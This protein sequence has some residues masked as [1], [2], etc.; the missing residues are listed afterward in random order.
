MRSTVHRVVYPEDHGK[1]TA[2]KGDRYSIAFF[3]HPNKNTELV[4][5]PS[6]I[7]R[8]KLGMAE[9]PDKAGG[10][11]MTAMEHLQSRL[12]ATYRWQKS[13]GTAVAAS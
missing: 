13:E 8:E 5:V 4:E 9:G 2:G 1:V 6:E 3:C 11:V 10:K 12:A 7:V